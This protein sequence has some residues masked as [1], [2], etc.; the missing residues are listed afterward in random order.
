[1]G[2]GMPNKQP[3]R[4]K[5]SG[6][7]KGAASNPIETPAAAKR[8]ERPSPYAG[9]ELVIATAIAARLR[10]G[11]PM[12]VILRDDGMPGGDALEEWRVNDPEIDRLMAR[13]RRD[14][15]DAIAAECLAIAD[16]T[17]GDTI[18]GKTGER[19]DSEWIQRSKLKIE[20]RL[21][22]LAKWDP[23]RYGDKL[24]VAEDGARADQIS[25]AGL[26]ETRR[27]S[28]IERRRQAMTNKH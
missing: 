15:F 8:A 16:D 6:R 19:P 20:T 26:P 13:A 24:E 21:K 4:R 27:A 23:K 22:L 25:N 28:L 18:V 14:G 12:V 5:A 17:S 1:M 2:R 9:K 11:E 3:G 10:K 7:A